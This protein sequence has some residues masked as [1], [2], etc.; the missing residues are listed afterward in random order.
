VTNPAQKSSRKTPSPG[1]SDRALVL[2]LGDQLT[3]NI[4]S[5][6]AANKTRDIILMCE[7]A[8]EATY[9]RHHKKKIAFLFSAMRHFAEEL[10]DAGWTVDYIKLDAP[11]N[12]GGFSGEVQRAIARHKAQKIIVTEPGEYRVLDMMHGWEKAFSLPVTILNDHRFICSRA[13]FA[14]WA[15]DGRKQLRMEF[16]Y[17]EMRRKTG[18]LMNGPDPEGGQWN[19]DHDN[20][21]PAAADLFMPDIARFKPDARARR[22]TL[23][24]PF[25]RSRTILVR[26]YT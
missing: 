20:R 3:L 18:L 13:E 23:L 15:N 17:R 25:R 14:E 24:K 2:V 4:S 9:V 26:R 7:V 10:R 19:F 8:D 5:L 21:K 12:T 6:K 16:F 11:G 22:K 1:A